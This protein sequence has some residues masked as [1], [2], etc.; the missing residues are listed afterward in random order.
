MGI[1]IPVVCK[2]CGYP[3]CSDCSLCSWH[4][5]AAQ[6]ECP[7]PWEYDDEDDEQ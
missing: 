6:C 5:N 1:T 7:E 2:L 4:C 3:V